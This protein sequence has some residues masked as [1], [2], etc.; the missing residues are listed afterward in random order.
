MGNPLNWFFMANPN[1]IVVDPTVQQLFDIEK[2][3]KA[4]RDN[5]LHTPD[6]PLPV[7]DSIEKP[8]CFVCSNRSWDSEYLHA[9]PGDSWVTTVGVGYERYPLDR[10]REQ[11]IM[12]TNNPGISAPQ[13]AEHV[14]GMAIA[15][16]R[17]LL[18]YRDKQRAHEW[19]RWPGMTDLAGEICT[20]VGLGGIGEAVASRAVAFDMTVRGIKRSIS[21]YDGVVDDLYRPSE[22]HSAL[23]DAHLV[24]ISVPLTDQTEGLIGAE[25]LSTVDSDGILIN[26]ARGAVVEMD[27]LESALETG[28]IRAAGLDVTDPEPLPPAS[29][30]WDRRDVLITPHCAGA[31]LKYPER[32]V[33]RFLEQYNRWIR[34]ETLVDRVV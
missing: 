17:R 28:N 6:D 22:L 3:P 14:F 11:N 18:E 24:V 26:V 23:K 19:R 21:E 13:I 30:L 25:E 33:D 2:V 4:L 20:V 5:H 15:F 8:V 27:A 7:I 9:L 34:G 10:F 31:S 12:F 1:P 29:P 16:N 32:Y